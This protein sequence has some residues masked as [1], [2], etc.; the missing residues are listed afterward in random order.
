MSSFGAG[1]VLGACK[2]LA[3][4]L[5]VE[6]ECCTS[7]H[8]EW[9]AG[10]GAECELR[11]EGRGFAVCCKMADKVESTESIIQKWVEEDKRG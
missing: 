5:G 2:D 10:E 4:A 1:N 11:Y 7:C 6:Q 8:S 9:E 3:E